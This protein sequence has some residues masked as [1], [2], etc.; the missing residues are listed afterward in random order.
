[1][2][3][4]RFFCMGTTKVN[5]GEMKRL[6]Q[7]AV[8]LAV[9]V[10]CGNHKVELC[11]KNLLQVYPDVLAEDAMLLAL[12]KCFHNQSTA[13]NFVKNAA[14]MFDK[15][16]V[17]PNF[18]SDTRWTTH[19][20]DCKKLCNGFKQIVSALEHVSMEG[21]NQMLLTYLS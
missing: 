16:Q 5:S 19:D 20:Q 10:G 2:V 7:H 13:T 14:E 4:D 17:I 9:W 1:M 21:R 6:L 8:L 11:F 15:K 3:N 18:P 12:S